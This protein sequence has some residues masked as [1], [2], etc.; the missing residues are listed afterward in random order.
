LE[1]LWSAPAWVW[2]SH[3]GDSLVLTGEQ[4]IGSLVLVDRVEELI[5]QSAR[6]GIGAIV[7]GPASLS[8]D[9]IA[10]ATLAA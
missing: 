1:R 6:V 10:R 4:L 3:S 5:A 8:E 7:T 2:R 9:R